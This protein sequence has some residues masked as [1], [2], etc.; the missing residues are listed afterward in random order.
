MQSQQWR[1]WQGKIQY[2]Q[3]EANVW[4]TVHHKWLFLVEN[5]EKEKVEWNLEQN[6]WNVQFLAAA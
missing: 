3:P 1:S 5:L 4:F 6:I 2:I